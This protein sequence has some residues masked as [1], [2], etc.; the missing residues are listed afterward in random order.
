MTRLI[1]LLFILLPFSGF[2]QK[3]I[4]KKKAEVK[5]E[6]DKY[7]TDNKSIN[8]TLSETDTSLVLNIPGTTTQQA[9][10]V[11]FFDKEGKCRS[12]KTTANCDSCIAKYLQQALQQ[13]K[14]NW[15]KINENQYISS[16]EEKLMIETPADGK[17]FSFMILRT[18]WSK[19][20]YDMFAEIKQ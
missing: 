9:N 4:N 1:I 13:G 2:A 19:I 7:I 16:F 20:L 14:Y 5:K 17:E 12:Q 3:Y 8:A 15:R 18:D 11:Y 6:L 10:F